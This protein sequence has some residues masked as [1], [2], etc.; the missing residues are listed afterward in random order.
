MK[1]F[2]AQLLIVL[3]LAST[4]SAVSYLTIT[5][6]DNS[7]NED[8]FNVERA[9]S[10]S[11]PFVRIAALSVNATSYLDTD[12][13]EAANLCYRV[14]AFNAAGASPYTSVVCGVTKATLSLNIAG[15]GS[16]QVTSSPA[17]T[18]C[19]VNC[20]VQLSGN[21]TVTLLAKAAAGSTFAGW[22]GVCSGTG[23]CTVTMDSQKSV[24]AN[25]AFNASSSNGANYGTD[26]D[27]DGKTDIAVYDGG[28]WYFIRSSNGTQTSV[29]WG[30]GA[31]DIPV[32]ADYDGDGKADIA[33]YNP[34]GVWSIIRS[35]DG[36]NTVVGWGGGAQDVPVPADY[37][38]DGK[39]DIAVYSSLSGMWSIIRS[40]DGGNTVVGWGGPGFIPVPGDYDG[41]GK[42]DIAVYSSS[43]GTW[44]IIRSSD[45][46]N[47]VVGWGGPGFIPVP[48]DYD[49]DGKTDIAVYHPS[50]V[51]SIIR[52]SDGGNTVVGWGGAAQDIPVPAD[53][54]GD[55]KTDI[56]IYRDGV[57]SIKRSSDGGNTI[58]GLGG[59]PQDIPLSAQ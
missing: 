1:S 8:G 35:S 15:T 55:G 18:I 17:G 58:V 54:D 23:S 31:Q 5:W 26:F 7:T 40:S 19:T 59:M 16:G 13:P 2:F 4:A 41:D 29:Q 39:A 14:N 22:S 42:A 30:D 51:W 27:G 28:T 25:F 47:T 12:L 52:S 34:I 9:T 46:G 3:L 37:D 21:S 33:V 49:G 53:Y 11:G 48:G 24:T 32:P 50:G 10:A 57:W 20:V 44:S 36:G 38:G 43:S 56:G 6:Q 45:G